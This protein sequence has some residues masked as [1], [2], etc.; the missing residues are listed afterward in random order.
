M[1]PNLT[2]NVGAFRLPTVSEKLR[3]H[4]SELVRIIQE[5]L[6][7]FGYHLKS[8]TAPFPIRSHCDQGSIGPP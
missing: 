5:M 4:L 1:T 3:A 7:I 8:P 6:S 2:A